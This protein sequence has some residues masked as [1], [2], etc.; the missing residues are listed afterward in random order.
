MIVDIEQLVE[1]RPLFYSYNYNNKRINFFVI[2]IN[3]RV[4]SYL[5][6]CRECY[7]KKLGFGFDDGH[8]YCRSCNVRYPV[9][10]IEKGLG[11]CYP[12]KI[13]GEERGGKYFIPL[14]I[15]QKRA[16]IF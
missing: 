5:D 6:A 15:L 10:E 1:K 12:I 8:I 3:G 7:P 11:S 16:D 14:K 4:T 13:T 9:D 2:K